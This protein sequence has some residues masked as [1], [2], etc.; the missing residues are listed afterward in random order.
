[1]EKYDSPSEHSGIFDKGANIE[2]MAQQSI[3]KFDLIN[4][5]T[6]GYKSEV[7]Q[8]ASKSP[9][10]FRPKSCSTSEYTKEKDLTV[11]D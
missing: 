4:I 1:M 9:Q 8:G 5:D 2:N 7:L 3:E 11:H 6:E 10:K